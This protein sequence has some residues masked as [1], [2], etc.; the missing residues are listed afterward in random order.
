MERHRI[1][2]IVTKNSGGDAT[3]AKLDAARAQRLPVIMV[4]RPVEPI[5]VALAINVVQAL[6]WLEGR[7]G[8]L[9]LDPA[10]G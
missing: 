4:A 1:E 7:P 3:R 6:A 8:A 2:I 5:P 9:P 10:K